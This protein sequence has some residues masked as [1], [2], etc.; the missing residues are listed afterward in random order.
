MHVEIYEDDQGDFVTIPID[1]RPST[2][3]KL[4]EHDDPQEG[5]QT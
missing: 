5:R 3:I 4:S 1:L 2:P